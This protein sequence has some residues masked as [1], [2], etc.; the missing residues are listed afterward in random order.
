M[1]I[2]GTT[3]VVTGADVL[4][5]IVQEVTGSREPFANVAVTRLLLTLA[6]LATSTVHTG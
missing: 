1:T 6:N 2:L 5:Q 4:E 3:R